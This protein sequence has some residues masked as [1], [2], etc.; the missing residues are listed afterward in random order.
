[1]EKTKV[2]KISEFLSIMKSLEE[3]SNVKGKWNVALGKQGDKELLDV[4]YFL[5]FMENL[6][7]CSDIEGK[8]DFYESKD[9]F[10]IFLLK[11]GKL[12]GKQKTFSSNGTLEL[13]VDYVDG[14][15]HGK[16]IEYYHSGEVKREGDFV[17]GIL[18]GKSKYFNRYFDA[19]SG[20]SHVNFGWESVYENGKEK[21]CLFF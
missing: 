4:G 1:M 2:L 20:K 13:S 3:H 19:E 12:H 11:N 5:L 6:E 10:T 14:I 18:H 21:E 8:W 9:N 7:T 16:Y 15:M 17:D